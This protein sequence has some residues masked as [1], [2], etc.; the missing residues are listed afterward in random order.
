MYK[1]TDL[2]KCISKKPGDSRYIYQ[3]E[4]DKVCFQQGMAYEDFTDVTRIIA[5]DKTLSGIACNTA[6]NPKNNEYQMSL[7][8]MVY[9]LFVKKTSGRVIK[10]QN[11]SDQQLAKELHKQSIKKFKIRKVQ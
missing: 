9:K 4:L 8:S 6:K 3:N 7:A 5:S 2:I 10:N 11:M 1:H